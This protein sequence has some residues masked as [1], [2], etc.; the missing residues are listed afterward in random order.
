M[1]A[2]TLVLD[3]GYQPLGVITWERAITL[4]CQGKVEIVEEYVDLWVRSARQSFKVPSV[5]RFVKNIFKKVRK[6]KFSR[7]NVYARDKGKCQYCSIYVPRED[8]TLDHVTP[9]ALNG[10]TEWTNV[11]VCCISCNRQKKDKP[12]EKS[13]MKLLAMPIKPKSLF[14][15]LHWMKGSPDSWKDYLASALYWHGELEQE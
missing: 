10:K 15:T 12:Y 4:W 2:K 1:E 9:R 11:V 7:E 14:Q 3:V 6:I 5:V 13:G 8:F